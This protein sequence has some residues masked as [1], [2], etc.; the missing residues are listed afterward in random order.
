MNCGNHLKII[1]G[2][3]DHIFTAESYLAF[4]REH[5]PDIWS[6]FELDTAQNF[7]RFEIVLKDGLLGGKDELVLLIAAKYLLDLHFVG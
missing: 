5:L 6:W 1:V 7:T 2:N 4:L 3:N